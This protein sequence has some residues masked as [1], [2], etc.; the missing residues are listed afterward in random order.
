MSN[1][2]RRHFV[3]AASLG[4][5]SFGAATLGLESFSQGGGIISKTQSDRIGRNV[6]VAAIT[7]N[8]IIGKDYKET[9][10]KAIQQMEIALPLAPDIFCLPEVFHIAGIKGPRPSLK[11]SSEDGTGNVIGP[12][13]VFAKRNN[14]Y[15]VCPVFIFDKGKFYNAAILID[16]QGNKI[17]EYRKARLTD[18]EMEMGLTPGPLDIPVFKTDFGKI[19][20]QICYDM[21]W[22]EGW[23]QLQ[24]K[25]AEIVFWSS[26]YAGG[27]RVNTKAWE[28]QYCVVSATRKDTTKICDITGQELAAS[29]NWSR[30]GVCAPVNLEKVFIS[31]YPN[32]KKFYSIQK[33][34]GRKVK[35]YSLYEEE[36][37]IIESLSPDVEV[38]DIL[39]EF[40][41]KT[42]R[43][44]LQYD[45]DRQNRLRI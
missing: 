11:S 16:R 13:Q 2:T 7:Q 43:D 28:N 17:G 34:Y 41:I 33:K 27:K 20:V 44:E 39:K 1:H 31:S 6:W 21:E 14:C 4:V 3:K 35:C 10:Q 5:A 29:G 15:V 37:S 8:N 42:Y 32:C 45:E 12:I 23:Q 25:G 18:G 26:A 38:A 40:N 30:W 24:K 36:F 9:V 22:A 19:G